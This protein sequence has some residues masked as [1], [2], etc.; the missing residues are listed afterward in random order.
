MKGETDVRTRRQLKKKQARRKRR[1]RRGAAALFGVLAVAVGVLAIHA[2]PGAGAIIW[3]VAAAALLAQALLLWRKRALPSFVY[4][5]TTLACLMLIIAGGVARHL[6]MPADAPSPAAPVTRLQITDAWPEDLASMDRLTYLDVRSAAVDDFSPLTALPALETLDAR[7]NAAFTQADY[8]ALSAAR[9]DVTILW[10]APDDAEPPADSAGP[11]PAAAPDVETEAGDVTLMGRTFPADAAALD[12]QNAGDIDPAAVSAALARLSSVKEVDLRGTPVS[13]DVIAWL[14]QANPDV[15]FMCSCAVPSGEMTTED[16]EVTIPGGDYDALQVWM[17]FI[18]YMPNLQRMDARSV[19]L[20]EAQAT[21]L[22]ADPRARKLVYQF[23]A[24]GRSL[25]TLDTEL[26]LDDVPM[27]S[28]DEVE[29]VVSAMPNLTRVSMCNCGLSDEIMGGLCDRHPGVKFVWWIHFGKYTLRTDATAFTTNLYD[30]NHY[31][32]TSATFWPL[33]YCTDLMMLDIGHCKLTNIEAIGKMTRLRVL[34][35][36]DNKITDIS[37][38]ANLNDLEY[39]EIFLNKISDLTPLANKTKLL[40]LNLYYNP[41]GDISP[42]LTCTALER[43]WIGEAGL[44]RSQLNKLRKG[45]P[46]CR[47]NARGSSSTGNGWRDHKR[48]KV[49]KKMYKQGEYIPFS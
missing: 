4:V 25:T 16:A 45:L 3:G 34:I 27:T 23:T 2:V 28:A 10:D 18:D 39:V 1:L 37:P 40:D 7:G 31:G 19:Q 41:I 11:A 46:N 26:N 43:L 24:F 22:T 42:I 13:A 35:L 32:Y 30:N 38:L 12:L 36:A 21:A 17:S 14:T 9:P 49:I 20:T 8:D 33:Q 44:S 6:S 47:V 5:L 48:Y 29:R 15:R